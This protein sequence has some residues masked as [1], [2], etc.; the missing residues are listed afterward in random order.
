ML[1]EEYTPGKRA[2]E[3][4]KN[5]VATKFNQSTS[6]EPFH[7]DISNDSASNEQIDKQFQN[8][9]ENDPSCKETEIKGSA[10][11]DLAIA[12]LFLSDARPYQPKSIYQGVFRRSWL[13]WIKNKFLNHLNKEV[14]C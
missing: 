12:E 9:T 2:I 4:A 3:R 1:S 5:N 7:V 8:E 10:S 13:L 11:Y 14:F 6:V